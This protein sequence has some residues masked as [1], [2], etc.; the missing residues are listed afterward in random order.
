MKLCEMLQE[1]CMNLGLGSSENEGVLKEMVNTVELDGMVANRTALV[2]A[3]WERE[4]L[5]STA[6]GYGIAIPHARTDAVRNIVMLF[7][8]SA[9]GV[10]FG[11][12]DGKPVHLFFM[13]ASPP[14]A[15]GEYLKVLARLAGLLKEEDFRKK[16]MAAE[17]CK[18]ILS[19]LRNGEEGD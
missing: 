10:E 12:M 18:D 6:I 3:L 4:R 15:S 16:L 8:R 2:D 9:A 5:G 19:I 1:N 17:S 14:A 13:I 11:A 7:G